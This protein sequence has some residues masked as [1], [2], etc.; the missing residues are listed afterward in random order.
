VV[1]RW[2]R[3]WGVRRSWLFLGAVVA[4]GAGLLSGCSASHTGA[5]TC[6]TARTAA[7]VPV[8]IEVTKGNVGCSTA[9]SIET[10]YAALI[11]DGDVSGTGGGAPV[12]VSG[13]TCQGYSTPE[14]L[15]TGDTSQCHT[16]TA[17]IL[18]VLLV[19]TAPPTP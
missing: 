12:T 6:G 10:S 18:A 2:H 4:C 8:T 16:S 19:P 15:Q 9:L 13:W 14:I 17:Q 3:V 1:G 11:K 5:G 7:G